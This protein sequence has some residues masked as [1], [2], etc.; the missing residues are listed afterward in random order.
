MIALPLDQGPWLFPDAQ[1]LLSGS[2]TLRIIRSNVSDSIVVFSNGTFNEGWVPGG[3]VSLGVFSTFRSS[4]R[5]LTTPRDSVEL[6]LTVLKDLR[7][8]WEER[9][10]VLKAGEYSAK[11]GFIR[12][13]GDASEQ[14][15][16]QIAHLEGV[17]L[18]EVRQLPEVV[19]LR[20]RMQKVLGDAEY[21]AFVG[22]WD[23]TWS[24][25]SGK[26]DAAS[27]TLASVPGAFPPRH[28]ED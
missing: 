24:V 25:Q 17:P 7:V 23:R 2:L 12:L 26:E 22:R 14:W 4:S 20:A 1:E 13:T 16:S 6:R 3:P 9:E 18:E 27:T 21:L 5:Y 15:I 10:G 8:S 19:A 28:Y 11:G